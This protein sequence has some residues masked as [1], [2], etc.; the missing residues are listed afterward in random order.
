MTL[1]E[2]AQIVAELINQ[3]RERGLDP[4]KVEVYATHGGSGDCNKLSNGFL[5]VTTGKEESG[6]IIMLPKGTP[7]IDFYVGN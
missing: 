3:V 1:I 6:P 4:E 7:Y 5:R 2:Y